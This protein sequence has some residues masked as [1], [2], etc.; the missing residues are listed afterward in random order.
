[1]GGDH[2][3]VAGRGLLPL[4]ALP[5]ETMKL[6]TTP[7]CPSCKV[8]KA[9][10]VDNKMNVEIIDGTTVD[11]L[12]ERAW[13]ETMHIQ[14]VPYLVLDDGKAVKDLKEIMAVLKLEASKC[15]A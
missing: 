11:G 4:A 14:T 8:V 12:T 13:S 9:F 5:V 6:F 10:I 3:G 1:M 15:P 7:T 2:P